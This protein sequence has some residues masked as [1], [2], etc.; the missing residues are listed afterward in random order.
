[1]RSDYNLT[2]TCFAG[3]YTCVDCQTN[4]ERVEGRCCRGIRRSS[5]CGVIPK[6]LELNVYGE[7]DNGRV[8]LRMLLCTEND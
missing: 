6:I 2:L 7:E 4:G 5:S 8:T 3:I 1:M